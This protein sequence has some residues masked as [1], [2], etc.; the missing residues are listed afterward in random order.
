MS[1]SIPKSIGS[2]EAARKV[3]LMRMLAR[4]EARRLG[5]EP[6][7]GAV[8]EARRAFRVHFGLQR[9][10][11]FAAFL[12]HAGLDLARFDALMKDFAALE[13]VLAHHAGA[14]ERELPNHYAI[15]R[16]YTFSEEQRR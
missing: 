1:N 2:P 6:T 9:L 12:E 5:I 3:V 14:V 10:E 8:S 11:T 13:A 7:D 15:H 4:R 16:A